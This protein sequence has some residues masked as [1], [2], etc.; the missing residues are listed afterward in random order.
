MAALLSIALIAALSSSQSRTDAP[1]LLVTKL[2][3]R[4]AT[5]TGC[6]LEL[7]NQYSRPAIAWVV[8][9][10]PDRLAGSTH[11]FAACYAM[12]NNSASI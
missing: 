6:K 7:Q 8:E 1:F 11:D 12:R 3:Q 2:E 9:R 10:L 5:D 4:I